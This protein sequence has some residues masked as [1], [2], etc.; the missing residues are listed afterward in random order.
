EKWTNQR[1]EIGYKNK[2]DVYRPTIRVNKKT[3]TTFNELTKNQINKAK[4][5]KLKNGRVKKFNI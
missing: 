5:E 2:S 1:G 3:P 4:Q